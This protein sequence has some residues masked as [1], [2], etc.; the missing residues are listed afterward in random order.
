MNSKRSI[1]LIILSA[2]LTLINNWTASAETPSE[3]VKANQSARYDECIQHYKRLDSL[4][5][6]AK[7]IP[8]GKSDGGKELYLFV[9]D[10]SGLFDPA[11]FREG[12]RTVFLINNGIHAGE[13]DGVDASMIFAEELLTDPANRRFLE[14]TVVCIIPFYNVDGAHQRSCCSRVNQN[15][16]SE[17]GFR[18]NALYLDL[19]RDFIKCDSRI[20]ELFVRIFHQWDPDVFLDTHVSNGADY[21][22]TMTL[23]RTQPD[24]LGGKTGS[25]M[26]NKYTG[27]LYDWMKEHKMEMSP[28]VHSMDRSGMPDSGI[29]DFLETPRFAT[30]FTA[31]FQCYGFIS[32]SHML[33]PFNERVQATHQVMK[34]LLRMTSI[35]SNEIQNARREDRNALSGVNRIPLN[36]ILDTTRYDNLPFRGYQAIYKESEATGL[37]QLHYDRAR[38][39]QKNIPYYSYYKG[40]DSVTVPAF[41][42]IPQA[43]HKVIR[44]LDLNQVKMYKIRH[45]TLVKSE[46]YRIE[47]FKTTGSPYEGHYLHYGTTVSIDTESVV[48]TAG[49][50]LIPMNQPANRFIMETL[51]PRCGDSYF[52]W[53]F[54][55]SVLD[56]KEG[57]SSYVFDSYAADIVKSDSELKR[58]L[59]AEKS[60][61]PQ[62]AK[63][64]EAQLDFIYR[65]SIYFEKGYNRYPV[66]R[67]IP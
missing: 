20:T 5:R 22:Y 24:K 43:W 17:Y 11:Y 35:H 38:P 46:V 1:L 56:Q 45:D 10:Q 54:F 19:N 12:E 51:E 67:I 42:A 3:R 26:R 55:D 66:L 61:D 13:P 50:Y 30:G 37:N 9:I 47:S 8:Y 48:L 44:L 41:Y 60:K 62:F 65:H 15:G 2:A 27:F 29:C 33:K 58:K 28:Y 23:I 14:T 25:L 34:G 18:A 31:Q 39:Y 59:E 7:M 16:P 63:N 49:D 64:Q 53:G 52:N 57:F 6:I 32:E 40:T 21:P 4:Y 36:W